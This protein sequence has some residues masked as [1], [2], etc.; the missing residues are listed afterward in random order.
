MPQIRNPLTQSLMALLLVTDP[1]SDPILRILLPRVLML[2]VPLPLPLL[3]VLH[4]V[5]LQVLT[6]SQLSNAAQE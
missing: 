2:A 4:Q 5:P 1:A 3:Q 6:F